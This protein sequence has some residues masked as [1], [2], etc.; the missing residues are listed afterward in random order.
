MCI[1]DSASFIQQN[2]YYNRAHPIYEIQTG[3]QQTAQKILLTS[4]S[5]EKKLQTTNLKARFTTFKKLDCNLEF[6]SKK[7][8]KVT[9]FYLDQ[10]YRIQTIGF[11]PFLVYRMNPYARMNA[12]LSIRNATEKNQGKERADFVELELGSALFLFKKLSIRSELKYIS[13]QF[14]G[15][16]GSIIEFNMLDGYKAVSY[17]HLT[18]PTSDLV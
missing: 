9:Q 14:Q 17:T 2:L 7:D 3:F 11:H 16:S 15:E 12:G 1:R 18:L 4:G 8:D 6:F 10:N 13:I 5:D